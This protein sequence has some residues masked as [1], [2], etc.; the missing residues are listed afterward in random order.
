[1]AYLL[2]IRLAQNP[3]K[4]DLLIWD[5]CVISNFKV[6]QIK[7]ESKKHCASYIEDDLAA[8]RTD[9]LENGYQFTI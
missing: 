4:V 9:K 8:D 1:M 5:L 2:E 7:A 6:F 3:A